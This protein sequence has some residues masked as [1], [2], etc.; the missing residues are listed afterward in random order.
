[1]YVLVESVARVKHR[2]SRRQMVAANFGIRGYGTQERDNDELINKTT[3]ENGA[4]REAVLNVNGQVI[5][6]LVKPD[7]RRLSNSEPRSGDA[8]GSST[9]DVAP[10]CRSN[11]SIGGSLDNGQR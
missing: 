11:K 6:Q 4:P 8:M 7:C 10:P 3:G 5:G 9:I 1:M 2:G